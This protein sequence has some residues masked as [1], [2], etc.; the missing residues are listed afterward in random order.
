MIQKFVC[1]IVLFLSVAGLKKAC[2]SSLTINW[3]ASVSPGVAGYNVYYGTSSGIYSYTLNA[4]NATSVT[5]DN[6]TPGVTYY[7]AATAY[8]A[9]G[10]QS[11]LSSE[12]SYVAPNGLTISQSSTSGGSPVLEFPV[13]PGHW[14]EVQASTNLQDWI[15]IWQSSTFSANSTVQ[16]SD[17]DAINFSSRFYRVVTH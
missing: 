2:A 4:G 8:D 15:S 11:F 7:F 16:F 12:I 17:P 1:L 6:L 14:Y 10:N 5:I 9:Y 3:N 13:A